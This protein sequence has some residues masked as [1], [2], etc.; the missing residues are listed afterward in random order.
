MMKL[1]EKF[2]FSLGSIF[3]G[4]IIGL[5]ISQIWF[6]R[7]PGLTAIQSDQDTN[8]G[9]PANDPAEEP[10]V[11]LN[12]E[13]IRDF[14]IEIE[15]AGPAQLI[16]HRVLSGEVVLDPNRVA[17]ITP[18]ISG[19]VV[20]INKTLGDAVGKGELMAIIDSRE[21]A[22]AKAGYL[23]AVERLS[24]A[25]TSFDREKKLWE[26]KISSEEDY[27][28]A[29]QALAEAGI[30]LRNAKQGLYSLGFDE[31][32][33][34]K[35]SDL[36]DTLYTRY[37][38]L[39]PFEGIVIGRQIGL[40]EV[41]TDESQIYRIVDLSRVWAE[42]TIYQN[43]LRVIHVGQLVTIRADDI[44]ADVNGNIEYISPV[45]DESTRTAIARVV[46]SNPDRAWRP[47]T[48]VTGQV[49]AGTADV[50]VAVVR[51]AI[52]KLSGRDVVFV[53]TDDGFVP[54]AVRVGRTDPTS[55]E[56]LSGIEPGQRYVCA[57]AFIL[58]AELSKSTFAGNDD[59]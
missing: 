29:R 5:A 8:A 31:N 36:P 56:I 32:Y 23:A 54:Q 24:L 25:Q 21:L 38:I 49:D 58:K 2:W 14:G 51:G 39:A 57:N 1:N 40:G 59:D 18:R 46:I 47:G 7:S 22:D 37:E 30:A 13:Q 45:I 33:L 48:F 35:L 53:Q 50:P 10:I 26:K 52:V 12:E 19:I 55:A 44:D 11:V 16:V 28:N 41:V 3:L 4:L 20:Q 27:F 43:D 34:T 17:Y 9:G 6:A 15:Q 42:L